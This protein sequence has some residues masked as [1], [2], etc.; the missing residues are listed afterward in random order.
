MT[1]LALTSN[2]SNAFGSTITLD[3]LRRTAPAVFA[4][5]ASPKTKHTYRFIPTNE[6]V[7]AL[8]DAGFEISA[9]AQTK[10]RAGSDPSYAKHMLRF[11]L[12][13]ERIGLDEALPE[14]VVVNSHGGDAAYTLL[15][16]LYRPLCT[17]G[18]LCRL[19]DFGI[20][21]V[22]HRK[23]VITD[24]VAGALE[25]ASQFGRIS[26][27][28]SA[29]VARVLTVD[30]QIAFARRAFEIRWANAAPQPPMDP[31]KLLQVRRPADDHPTLWH[32]F[33]RC[34][35]AVMAGGLQYQTARG[36]YVTTRKIR[37]IREDVRI[38]TS[39]WQATVS[40]IEA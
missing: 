29:M 37:N 1:S 22:P 23:S 10:G 5:E 26:A 39:L 6:V 38:N 12:A 40:I 18:L 31:H 11:R 14:C 20:V 33:N 24:V 13:R 27:S 25:I 7:N 28:V 16:G 19:G 4:N 2:Y 35:E 36:R 21:R 32:V 30:E 34:Q 8:L 9:A 15:A 17:N 3:A